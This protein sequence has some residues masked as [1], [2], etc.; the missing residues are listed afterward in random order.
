MTVGR[1]F[2]CGADIHREVGGLDA[3]GASSTDSTQAQGCQRAEPDL[4]HQPL[5]IKACDAMHSMRKRGGRR[6]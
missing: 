3:Y 2:S 1:Y 4:G 5:A 6:V